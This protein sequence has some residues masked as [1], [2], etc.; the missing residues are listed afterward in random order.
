MP[1]AVLDDPEGTLAMLRDSVAALASRFPGPASIRA[2]RAGGADRDPALWEAM[3]QAGWTSILL[4][5]AMGGA[6]LTL[7]EQ[8]AVSEALGRAL[9]SE[10]LA[11]SAV[12][13]SR[14]L[15]G[16]PQSAER[17][18]LASGLVSGE[19]ILAP[20]LSDAPGRSVKLRS[21]SGGGFVLEGVKRH[22]DFALSATDFLVSAG[23]PEGVALVCVPAGAPGVSVETAAGVD[24]SAIGTL[25]FE[26]CALPAE[27]LL[28]T[29]ASREEMLGEAE[30]MARVALAAE[31]AGIASRAVEITIDY[32]RTRVQF[33][34]PIASFQVIQH[35]LVDMWSDA[36][37]ACAAVVNAVETLALDDARAGQMAVLAAKARAGDAATS[38]CRR[39]VHL[40]G[41]MGFTDECDIGL[42]LKRAI[43]LNATLGQPEDLRLEFVNLE[44]AA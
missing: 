14:L 36:E 40:H 11:I 31:L 18:R 33:G 19:A 29:A 30:R 12:L 44:R 39:A 3:T 23:T 25:R 16:S 8:V 4:P 38:I 32:T 41:A 20:A 35:R 21:A 24:G 2:K 10:P 37:F 43:S 17:D 13:S 22:V 1:Q 28:A 15:A 6:G 9:I 34:K 26:Q 7:A 27:A 42:Y 5:E